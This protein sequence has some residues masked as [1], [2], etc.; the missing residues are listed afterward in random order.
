MPNLKDIESL[1][2]FLRAHSE[3]KTMISF[4]SIGDM[5]SVASAYGLSRILKNSEIRTP[6]FITSN[7]KFALQEAGISFAETS[8]GFD[9]NAKMI[10]LVDVNNFEDCSSFE[11]PLRKNSGKVLIIDHHAATEIPE[12]TVF[13]DESYNSTASIIYELIKILGIECD[14]K[15]AEILAIGIYSDSAE[16]RNANSKSFIQIGELLEISQLSFQ[17]LVEKLSKIAHP[18]AREKTI[19]ELFSSETMIKKGMLFVKGST[20]VHAGIA[21]DDAIKI[22]A[23]VALFYSQSEKEIA[24]SARC[25]PGLEVQMNMHLG[26]LM[27]ALAG[28]IGGNGGG[29]PCAAGAYGPLKD[30]RDIFIK[31]FEEKVF[32]V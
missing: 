17:G 29:H 25:R 15:M 3:D 31:E 16:F 9:S 27:K 13:N 10:A 8:N 6:D 23:D 4:H 32:G 7:A 2:D 19:D 21:A 30:G 11:E 18:E 1:A 28:R 5:D 22:G 24:F 26:K 20:S 12:A 14:R